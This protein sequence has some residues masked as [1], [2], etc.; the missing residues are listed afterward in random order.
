MKDI[1]GLIAL[2]GNEVILIRVDMCFGF[3]LLL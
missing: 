3:D 1:P 2:F